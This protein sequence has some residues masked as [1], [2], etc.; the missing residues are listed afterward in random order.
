MDVT[1]DD[2]E[3]KREPS[4]FFYLKDKRGDFVTNR[5]IQIV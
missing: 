2:T 1:E 4:I 3:L 5:G